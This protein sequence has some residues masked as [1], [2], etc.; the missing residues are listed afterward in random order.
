MLNCLED[1]QKLILEDN[2]K[3]IEKKKELLKIVR[4]I[5]ALSFCGSSAL[6]GYSFVAGTKNVVPT[7]FVLSSCS[8]LIASLVTS[9]L[10][11]DKIDEMNMVIQSMKNGIE[12]NINTGRGLK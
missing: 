3:N 4:K 6:T 5:S 10:S 8:V 9:L 1:N 11:D 2:I 12:S 7:P